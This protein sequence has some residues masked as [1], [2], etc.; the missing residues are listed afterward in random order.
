MRWHH[1]FP[2]L[3]QHEIITYLL[4]QSCNSPW[5]WNLS[6]NYL[7]TQTDRGDEPYLPSCFL[8]WRILWT[9]RAWQAAVHGV[10]KSWTQFNDFHFTFHF[11]KV[12]QKTVHFF[13]VFLK[14]ETWDFPD[15]PVVKNPPCNAEDAGSI[16]DQGTK[17]PRAT[18]QLSPHT[19]MRESVCPQRGAQSCN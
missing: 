4:K 3:R 1:I 7:V 5:C 6:S 2:C 12:D 13:H 10:A 15:G 11:W 18:G 16:P 9:E 14:K 19:I 8:T 17:I